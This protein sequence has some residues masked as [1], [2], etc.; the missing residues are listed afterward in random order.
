MEQYSGRRSSPPAGSGRFCFPGC[1]F[2]GGRSG[3][4]FSE[5]SPG[6]TE[7][8][9]EGFGYQPP[10]QQVPPVHNKEAPARI[11]PN[12][13]HAESDFFVVHT[14]RSFLSHIQK[15]E[16]RRCKPCAAIVVLPQFLFY[17]NSFPCKES[18]AAY[19]LEVRPGYCFRPSARM[20]MAFPGPG[21]SAHGP[22][23]SSHQV[24]VGAVNAL[25]G[26]I[27]TVSLSMEK[28]SSSHLAKLSVLS[29]GSFTMTEGVG[30]GWNH[31]GHVVGRR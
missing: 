22:A 20:C 17:C 4:R 19:T 13:R 6:F 7:Y 21:S 26:V 9:A 5:T 29:T 12:K 24:Q 15:E 8:N 1:P 14:I 16:Q 28:S 10:K 31:P 11:S 30:F 23:D 18:E 2:P 3:R 25:P 27:M